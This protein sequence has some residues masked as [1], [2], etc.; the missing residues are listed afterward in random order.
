M[1]MRASSRIRNGTSL[2]VLI[3][4]PNVLPAATTSRVPMPQPYLPATRRSVAARRPW[5]GWCPREGSNLRPLPAWVE[6]IF[7]PSIARWIQLVITW[8][9]HLTALAVAEAILGTIVF[10]IA[11]AASIYLLGT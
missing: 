7:L 5:D 4:W 6:R 10:L 8:M 2:C 3:E 11:A 9:A 1:R